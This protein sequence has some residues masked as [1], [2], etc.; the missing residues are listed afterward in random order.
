MGKTVRFWVVKVAH[1]DG[2]SSYVYDVRDG[3]LFVPKYTTK[4][5]ATK[6][7]RWAF[8]KFSSGRYVIKRARLKKIEK[9]EYEINTRNRT[10]HAKTMR[11][12]CNLVA[13]AAAER[14]KELALKKRRGESK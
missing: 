13:A 5:I 8:S 9:F 10:E 3:L 14:L 11:R 1:K 2:G 7:N 12:N 6:K 4:A